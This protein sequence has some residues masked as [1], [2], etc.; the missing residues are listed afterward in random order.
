MDAITPV[1][2]M[3]DGSSMVPGE[4][5]VLI[6]APLLVL[7]TGLGAW[8]WILI[9]FQKIDARQLTPISRV[10]ASQVEATKTI[11]N[12]PLPHGIA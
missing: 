9:A 8:L 10:R 5:S 3:L 4:L 11:Q 2:A 1:S 12:A 6:W 7:M